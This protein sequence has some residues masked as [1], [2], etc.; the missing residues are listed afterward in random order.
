[1]DAFDARKHAVDDEQ[2]PIL[3]GGVEKTVATIARN[4]DNV[5][6]LRQPL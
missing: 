3:A 2:V 4:G 1:M 5:T 6:F